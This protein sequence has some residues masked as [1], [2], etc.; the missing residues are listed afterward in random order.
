M[1]KHDEGRNG[2]FEGHIAY[3]ERLNVR[4]RQVSM[5]GKKGEEDGI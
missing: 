1:E 4:C 3:D 2:E 5:K